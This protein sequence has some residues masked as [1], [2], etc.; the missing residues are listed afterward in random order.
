MGRQARTAPRSRLLHLATGEDTQAELLHIVLM[1]DAA[2]SSGAQGAT[3]STNALLAGS[4]PSPMPRRPRHHGMIGRRRAAKTRWR[5]GARRSGS[6]P[7]AKQQQQQQ[8]PGTRQSTCAGNVKAPN[9]S[10]QPGSTLGSDAAAVDQSA[11]GGAADGIR[12]S[13]AAPLPNPFV[14]AVDSPWSMTLSHA[15]AEGVRESLGL[16][17]APQQ[18]LSVQTAAAQVGCALQQ[19]TKHCLISATVLGRVGPARGR[20]HCRPMPTE[21]AADLHVLLSMGMSS[22]RLLLVRGQV[23]NA[24]RMSFEGRRT[25]LLPSSA[26]TAPGPLTQL[27]LGGPPLT[28]AQSDP[29][30]V[31]SASERGGGCGADQGTRHQSGGSSD[32]DCCAGGTY[33]AFAHKSPDRNADALYGGHA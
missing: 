12:G 1:Q 14:P 29:I 7:Q 11:G 6:D 10:R 13:E 23:A 17:P 27:S 28:L 16:S 19:L 21:P 30:A 9:A 8:A 26:L 15:E 24:R 31:A 3:K 5:F 25:A 4:S 32:G 2:S 20:R 18:Q 33:A 22:D